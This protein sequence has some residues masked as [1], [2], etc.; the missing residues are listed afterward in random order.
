[1]VDTWILHKSWPKLK[2]YY[3]YLFCREQLVSNQKAKS[4]AHGASIVL[5]LC[6]RRVKN[7]YNIYHLVLLFSTSYKL[8]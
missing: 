3:V 7:L 5:T 8:W 4:N 6:S 2:K 1:M